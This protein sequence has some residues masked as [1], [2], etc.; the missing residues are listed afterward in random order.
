MSKYL[1]SYIEYTEEGKA[2]KV[3]VLVKNAESCADVERQV[4]QVCES[5]SHADIADVWYQDGHGILTDESKVFDAKVGIT[6]IDDKGKEKVQKIRYI[7]VA[8]DYDH[9]KD[10]VSDNMGSMDD[11]R[12]LAM[13]E[14]DINEII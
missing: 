8:E 4:E 13:K 6:E 5:V 3:K 1:A 10:L 12:I 2:E 9:A 11:W 14:V 7:V